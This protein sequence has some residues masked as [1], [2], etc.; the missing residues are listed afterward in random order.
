MKSQTTTLPSPFQETSRPIRLNSAQ[1]AFRPP[2]YDWPVSIL[3]VPFDNV[4]I[5]GAVERIIAM[6]CKRR[7]HYVVTANVDFLVQAR[8]DVELRRILL[9]ADLVLC[10]GTP[11]VWASRLLGN[12][13]RERVAGSDVVPRLIRKASDHGHSI[14][15][16]GA[17]EGVAGEAAE[18]LRRQ[19]PSLIIAG[20]H[21]PPF[22]AL[23][24]MDHEETVK[25]IRE[26]NPDVLLV[27]FGCPKQEKWIAMH[28]RSLGVPVVI[29]V[30]A[31]LDFL[32]NRVRRAPLWMQRCG[33]EWSYRLMQEPRR[34]FRRYANDIL[35]FAP[36]LATQWR[37]LSAKPGQA[38]PPA[39]HALFFASNWIH[40]W[41]GETLTAA[42]LMK[43]ARFWKETSRENHH[44]LLDLSQ[45]T[46]I[47]STGAALLARWQ[48]HLHARSR[49]L[50]LLAPSVAMRGALK[51]LRLQ[52][53]FL[54]AADWPEAQRMIR[55]VPPSASPVTFK[56]GSRPLAWRGEVTA[57]NIEQVWQHT[58][59]LLGSLGAI[60]LP[61][62]IDLSQLRFIDSS[63]LGL[64]LRI[65]RWGR[66]HET[67]VRFADPQP[68]VL[69]VLQLARL[70]SVL[71]QDAA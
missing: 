26:A 59:G 16:L 1:V 70:D 52:D 3:G 69:N 63:G 31:T 55:T 46:A 41:A 5:D 10:D 17:G 58:T 32:A 7:P 61:M 28:Y 22:S 68:N 43:E 45:V 40:I 53:H 50:V 33:M 51:D 62:V 60:R 66:Q 30:G 64:M 8:E 47:D 9:E 65:N 67:D 71:L 49:Q 24:E 35:R 42:S 38:A 11:L 56:G 39:R 29:G 4:T 25:R 57:D 44:C 54:I 19:Y 18:R 36:A 27:S 15:L 20:H 37:H 21:S 34:L 6:V 2:T 48:Q 14:F 13:L 12:P 23:L